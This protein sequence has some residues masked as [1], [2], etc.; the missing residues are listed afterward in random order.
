M[1]NF[2]GK[3]C[4]ILTA[5]LL[6]GLLAVLAAC[7]PAP[8]D[9]P[10]V[11]TEGETTLMTPDESTCTPETEKP[12]SPAEPRPAETQPAEA[13]YTW[14]NPIRY[15]R[16]TPA[17]RD[18]FIL[19]VGD[20]WYMTGTLPPYGLESEANRTKGVPLYK[21]YDMTEW[22]FVDYIVKTPAE[23]ESKW[24]SE[25]FWA[26]E[27]FSHNGK[28]YVTVNCCA[29]DGSNHGFLFAVADDVEG[30]YTVMNPDA[31]LALGNDA[32]LFVDT[33]GQTYVFAS[34]IM[35]A[36]ID[37]DTLTLLSGWQTPVTPVKGS[38]A[39]NGERPGVGFE[40][41]F[42]LTAGGKYYM[43]YST[44]SRGYEVGLASA[45]A[46]TGTWTM[47]PDPMYGGMAQDRCDY[48]GGIYEEGYYE[49]QDKYRECGHNSVF[50]GPDGAWWIAAHA[51]VHG[52]GTPML[53]IDRLVLDGE[54]GILCLD[55]ATGKTINGPTY[56]ERSVT[57]DPA[58]NEAAPLRALD[59]WKYADVGAV[60][61]LP[62]EV[63]LLLENGF[64]RS[65]RVVWAKTPDTSAAGDFTV[66]GTA[67]YGDREFPV[68][69]RIHVR[70]VS[71]A[72]CDF[73][74]MKAGDTAFGESLTNAFSVNFQMYEPIGRGPAV[75][76]E[77]NGN[78][79]LRNTAY[80]LMEMTL[81][82]KNGYALSLDW[83]CLD[84]ATAGGIAERLGG[85]VLRGG[86]QTRFSHYEEEA[87]VA[88][89]CIGA[90]GMLVM[91]AENGFR[92]VVKTFDAASNAVTHT[93]TFISYSNGYGFTTLSVTDRDGRITVYAGETLLFTAELG[94][95]GSYDGATHDYYRSVTVKGADGVTLIQVDN[96]FL[97]VRP[98]LHIVSRGWTA[99]DLDNL[100]VEL[101]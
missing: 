29:V 97:T 33:D 14:S 95:V 62:D 47:Y 59:V 75:I 28:F 88:E 87:K 100:K 27:L 81:P 11:P 60:C 48:Y 35:Y 58:N 42:V 94:D 71:G 19:K 84:G 3:V 5:T 55:T 66:S 73:E 16:K 54:R 51:Y 24:Y 49:N 9:P 69:A 40:G 56:G 12:T 86:D 77:E 1:R 22:A 52:N 83:R 79:F 2:L 91:P 43:F 6:F 99:F 44:W 53:I 78:R 31:P 76:V 39:W 17:L 96:G 4:P 45:D 90:S 74:D 68:T 63:D 72:S 50:E 89:K 70:D 57:Y 21:S 64:R 85:L 46:V 7:Q 98:A 30:P 15:E 34:N 65:V 41:P 37:L 36:K 82:V 101:N 20:A 13:T 10:T 18:P 93:E 32:H 8:A 92:V 80:L 23:S 38:D 26:A 61:E 25:R 67:A